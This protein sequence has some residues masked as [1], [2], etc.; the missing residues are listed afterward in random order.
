MRIVTVRRISQIFF[1]VVFLWFCVAATLGAAWWQLRGWPINWL[2]DLDPLTSLATVLAT[3]RLYATL[4]WSLVA[5]GLTLFLGRFFCGFACPLGT[6]NQAT[7]W[8][9]RR[10][11][12][13]HGRVEANRHRPAQAWKY[14]FLAFFLAL[15]FRG[16]VQTGLIDPLPLLH[17]S[18]N[19]ALLPLADNGLGL[20]SGEPRF[21]ASA[22]F[23]G[24]VF[25]GVVGLNLV[26]PRFFCRFICPL[27]ALFGMLGRFSPWRIGKTGGKCGECRICE[28][29]CEGACRPSGIFIAGECVMCMNCLD[30]CPANRVTFAGKP[31]TAG[32]AG[33]PDLS[34]RGFIVAGSGVLLASLWGVGGL[35]GAGRDAG[36]IRPPGALDEDRFL[37]RCIRCGQCMRICP[38]NIIQPAL[39]EAGVQ[40]LWTPAVDYRLGR[41]GCQPNC[42]ACGQV[43][44][45][46]AIRPLSLDEKQGLGDFAAQGPIRM[47]TAF[48]DRGRCLPWAMDRPCLVCHELCPVSPKAIFTRTGFETIRDG[49]ALPARAQ[50]PVVVLEAIIPTWAN[51]VSGDY[52][53]RPTGQPEAALRRITGLAGVGLILERPLTGED[54]T[55]AGGRVDIVVRLERPF[56][57][58]ARCIGCGMCEQACPVS[59]RRAI[60]VYSENESR[61]RSGRLL[62]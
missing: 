26:M 34:R 62:I 1:L 30:R 31:S 55:A 11:L 59:G 35:A 17:R 23:I 53:L 6:I 10:G 44:P 33:L 21:Y 40:G 51:I 60:R 22:W 19:L 39:L 57:D 58:P 16:S 7:G 15:A 24:V 27:G 12:H 5:I 29:Y 47:G 56:M 25:L 42:I 49:R 9:A 61:S 52:Y 4:A 45:T 3:G 32:E 38:A 41:S 13:Q 28:E 54:L 50:G 48:V 37:A 20:L 2:L 14:Y 46:A 8:V 36:L 18:V 43:C